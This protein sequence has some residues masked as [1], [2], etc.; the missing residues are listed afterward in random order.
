VPPVRIV[1]IGA[2]S[3]GAVYA[4]RIAERPDLAQ[5][6]GVAEPR[7][8]RRISGAQH[9]RDWRELARAGIADAAIIATPDDL[10][11]EPACAFAELG[12]HVMLEKPIAPAL[13]ECERVVRAVERAGVML[14]VCHVLRYTRYTEAITSIVQSGR[15]GRVMSIEHLEPVGYW[16]QAHAFV[17]GN[18]RRGAPMLLAKSCHDLDWLRHVVGQPCVEVASFGELTHFRAAEKPDGAASRCLECAIEATC[19]YSAKKL[20]LGQLAAGN[21]GWP[22]DVLAAHPTA[23]SVLAALR[24]GPYGRC[25]YDCDNQAVDH[26]VVILRFAGGA[27]ASFTMTAF[28]RGR[29][30]ETRLFGTRGELY[31]DGERIE[32]FDFLTD[33]TEAIELPLEPGHG[34]GDARLVD[35]FCE[36]VASGDPSKIRSGA[37]ESLE[38]HRIVFAAEESRRLGRVVRL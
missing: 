7:E 34:G 36:A 11:V 13:E 17:R 18:W 32:I 31:G 22:V 1:L 8:D 35:A 25:V 30:R 3:R 6:V 2:G 28:T 9:V 19:P 29:D 4:N 10:H 27:T 16:H 24:D 23:D 33:R 38:S 5:I 37:A 21:R 26:Q 20:Y 14:A 12:V 15:I